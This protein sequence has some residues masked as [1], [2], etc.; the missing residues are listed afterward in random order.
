[1]YLF[2][3][4]SVFFSCRLSPHLQRRTPCLYLQKEGVRR[5]KRR[6]PMHP[7]TTSPTSRGRV[8][9][10]ESTQPAAWTSLFCCE[11]KKISDQ[12][13]YT[14]WQLLSVRRLQST[15]Y[16]LKGKWS[17]QVSWHYYIFI[18]LIC[19]FIYCFKRRTF[20]LISGK[21]RTLKK[22]CFLFRVYPLNPWGHISKYK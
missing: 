4:F 20:K 8:N 16:N 17:G 6:E 5:R 1:M 22:E 2:I 9:A 10:G 18:V 19:V 12:T 11:Q 3:Y 21:W 15:S 13:Y 14:V 7:Q